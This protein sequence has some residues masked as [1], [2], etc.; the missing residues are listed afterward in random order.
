MEL[1]V[2]YRVEAYLKGNSIAAIRDKFECGD[3]CS[4]GTDFVEL[5]SVEDAE[6]Y[7]DLMHE[8]DH[9]YDDE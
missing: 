7:K 5:V 6:T 2:T 3:F 1:R 8:W 4:P 9:A